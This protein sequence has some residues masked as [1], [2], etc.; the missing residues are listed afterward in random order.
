MTRVTRSLLAPRPARRVRPLDLAYQDAIGGGAVPAAPILR[1]V[2]NNCL[3]QSD[4]SSGANTAQAFRWRYYIGSGN[5]KRIRLSHHNWALTSAASNAADT[6]YGSTLTI[7]PCYIIANGISLPSTYAGAAAR[8]LADGAANIQ[9]DWLN[10]SDFGLGSTF[11]KNSYFD[12][13]GI[14]SRPTAIAIPTSQQV[15]VSNDPTNNQVGWFLPANTTVTNVGGTGTF[16][17][18][19]TALSSR[20]SGY[21]PIVLGEYE[22]G[23]PATWL[24][25][26][27][28]ISVGQGDNQALA[29]PYGVAAMGRALHDSS[30][31]TNCI[32]YLSMAKGGSGYYDFDTVN[33]T[34]AA[35]YKGYCNRAW[36]NMGT[37]DFGV[38]GTSRTP[39]TVIASAR[40]AWAAMRAA[41]ITK[42]VRGGL[43]TRVNNTTRTAVDGSD[44]TLGGT[45]WGAGGNVELW[46][47]MM[48]AEVSAGRIDVF[49]PFASWKNASD[50]YKW[51]QPSGTNWASG[52]GTHPSAAMYALLAEEVRA[53]VAAVG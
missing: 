14:A 34:R 10:A 12:V 16:T 28:S 49:A 18:T 43:L 48:A 30:G 45:G 31:L 37:N 42:I 50:P 44:Q 51:V 32:S 21:R 20:A 53:T 4:D 13:R 29:G 25:F 46:H 40:V 3:P 35:L 24:I 23:D 6:L 1:S 52:D 5:V 33:T 39:E 19:G 26:G 41:G 38:A 9:D 17:V 7:D 2:A 27:D 22:T 11:P 8:V 47:A 15:V 36:D